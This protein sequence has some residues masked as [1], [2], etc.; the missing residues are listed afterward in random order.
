M[1]AGLAAFV[2]ATSQSRADVASPS[3]A[4]TRSGTAVERVVCSDPKLAAEDR[5]MARLYEL[6]KVSAFARGPSNQPTAQHE[7]LKLRDEGCAEAGDVGQC[8][9]ASYAERNEQLT[10]AV[11]FTHPDVALPKLRRLDPAAAP[12]FK[13]IYLYARSSILSAEDRQ[14][15][16]G[17]LEPYVAKDGEGWGELPPA[18][19]VKSDHDFA[20]FVGIRS[21][22]LRDGVSGRAFPCAAMVR[23]P[24]LIDATSP[25][26][27]S[28]MDNSVIVSD[29][30]DTLPSLPKFRSLVEKRMLGMTDC[31]GGTIRFAYYRSFSSAVL[32]ARLATGGQLHGGRVKPFP[33]RRKVTNAD[34]TAALAEL[35]AY[36]L[37]YGR[38][39][40]AQAPRLARQM[41]YEMLDEAWQC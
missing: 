14:R 39:S 38:A 31:G 12:L 23:K 16:A 10:L 1:F 20:E 21:A 11:L 3:F 25:R 6:T 36:Y 17:L 34:I 4:C 9:T 24:D 32:A 28:S 35:S 27:G 2:G 37:R 22:Y 26:F 5:L 7:W 30:A 41:I 33:P 15:V 29:C 8:L 19:A 40:A 18:E 13:A